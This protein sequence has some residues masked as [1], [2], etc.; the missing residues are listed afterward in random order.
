MHSS[1]V[2]SFQINKDTNMALFAYPSKSLNY[3]IIH[4][5]LGHPTVHALKQ[6]LKQFDH[7]F[8]LD[9]Y[10]TLEFVVPV[11]LVKVICNIFYLLKQQ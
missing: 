6:I 10:I 9:E 7:T 8:D 1:N 4:K 11:S 3:N 5:R 2:N